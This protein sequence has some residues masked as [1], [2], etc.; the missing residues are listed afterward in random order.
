MEKKYVEM[1]ANASLSP[2]IILK[3]M[4]RQMAAANAANTAASCNSNT[5]TKEEKKQ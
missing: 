3:Q 2:Q 5:I 4:L 1:T